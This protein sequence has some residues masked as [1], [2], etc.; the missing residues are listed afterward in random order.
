MIPQKIII[1]YNIMDKVHNRYIF[2]GV[3]KVMHGLP[4]EVRITLDTIVPHLVHYGYHTQRKTQ[5]YGHTTVAQLILPWLSM[6][7]V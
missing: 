2:A 4:Q 6:I 1:A 7:S 5:Y 3:T